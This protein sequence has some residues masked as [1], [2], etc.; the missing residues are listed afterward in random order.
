M[1]RIKAK[2]KG[3]SNVL[4]GSVTEDAA[5]ILKRYRDFINV[6]TMREKAPP[7]AR[8]HL[9]NFEQRYAADIGQVVLNALHVADHDLFASLARRLKAAPIDGA[10]DEV[11]VA[12]RTAWELLQ[13]KAHAPHMVK[14]DRPFPDPDFRVRL[15]EVLEL[16][17]EMLP[18]RSIDAD[19]FRRK[20]KQLGVRLVAAGR[21]RKT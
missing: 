12:T 4:D 2:D 11:A 14:A 5:F 18:G 20:A 9:D 8:A 7:A 15:V 17:Q 21:P 19:A 16:V 10:V 13:L 6:R 3:S 1:S